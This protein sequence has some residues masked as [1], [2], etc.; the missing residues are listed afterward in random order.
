M[1]PEASRLT[2]LLTVLITG[3]RIQMQIL[4]DANYNHLDRNTKDEIQKW[5][6]ALE[7]VFGDERH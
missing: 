2:Q 6:D 1:T 5:Y 4:V 3:I 7:K